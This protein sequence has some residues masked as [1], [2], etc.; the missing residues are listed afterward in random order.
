[1]LFFS[2][3]H[4][5][6]RIK[7]F[8]LFYPLPYN[9]YREQAAASHRFQSVYKLR[10][11]FY[12]HQSRAVLCSRHFFPQLETRTKLVRASCLFD[13]SLS[14]HE[15]HLQWEK[16]RRRRFEIVLL[17]H[18]DKL[19]WFFLR[20]AYCIRVRYA[21]MLYTCTSKLYTKYNRETLPGRVKR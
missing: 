14:V 5:R 19:F 15:F 17:T 20:I 10:F 7:L 1:M 11:E 4:R 9:A 18:V 13:F 6:S 2:P 3:P 12:Q 8:F 16:F 21:C